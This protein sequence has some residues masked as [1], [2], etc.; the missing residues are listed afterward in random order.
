MCDFGQAISYRFKRDSKGWRIIISLTNEVEINYVTSKQKGAIGI[1]LNEHHLAVTEVDE[2]GAIVQT[3]DIYFRD[4]NYNDTS[5]QT[6]SGLGYAIGQVMDLSVA[7]GKP[8]VIEN[9]D[10]KVA[11]SQVNKGREKSYNRMISLF[12]I[13]RLVSHRRFPEYHKATLR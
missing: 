5:N 9:L 3:Q 1:D 12:L 7:T 6:K 4:K 8:V 13:S 2:R 11:K 10:F